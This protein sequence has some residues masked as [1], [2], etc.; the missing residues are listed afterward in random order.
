MCEEFKPLL[1]ADTVLEVSHRMF[2]NELPALTVL[3][4]WQKDTVDKR[5]KTD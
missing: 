4:F 1:C 2:N 5:I 3:T